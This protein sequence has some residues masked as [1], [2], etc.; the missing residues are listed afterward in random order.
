MSD[1]IAPLEPNWQ[2]HFVFRV[3]NL[4]TEQALAA[5]G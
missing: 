5:R 4:P 3:E 2:L 1:F